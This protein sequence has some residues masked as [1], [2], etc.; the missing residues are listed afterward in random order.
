MTD[1]GLR[2]VEDWT[3][4]HPITTVAFDDQPYDPFFNVNRPEDLAQAE[5]I[6][7]RHRP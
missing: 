3:K 1:E 7:D 6:M 2:K 5:I 4:R